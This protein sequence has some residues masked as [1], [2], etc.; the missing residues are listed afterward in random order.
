MAGNTAAPAYEEMMAHDGVRVRWNLDHLRVRQGSTVPSIPIFE[1]NVP[2]PAQDTAPAMKQGPGQHATKHLDLF[3]TFSPWDYLVDTV[4][5]RANDI[6]RKYGDVELTVQELEKFLSL[7]CR[8][9]MHP[10]ATH[11]QLWSEDAKPGDV[12]FNFGQYGMSRRR[13][14][15]INEVVPKALV[16]DQVDLN[17]PLAAVRE[18]IA[19]WCRNMK[20]TNLNNLKKDELI[21]PAFLV[22]VSF[23]SRLFFF[24][25][26][27]GGLQ[28]RQSTRAVILSAPTRPSSSTHHGGSRALSRFQANHTRGS[29]CTPLS[30]R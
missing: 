9:S 19:E 28:S 7:E 2:I 3:T 13:F 25:F 17:D 27:G 4:L 30:M 14:E 21:L 18:L 6:L 29:T 23:L 20:V 24:F 16:P 15:R 10:H 26:W 22:F 5:P 11:Q 8:S 1:S 12:L